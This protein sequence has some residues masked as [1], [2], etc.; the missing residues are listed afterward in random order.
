MRLEKRDMVVES[1]ILRRF[2]HASV[3]FRRL[4]EEMCTF[5]H[6]IEVSSQKTKVTIWADST[7]RESALSFFLLKLLADSNIYFTYCCR[8][9]DVELAY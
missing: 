3:P 9:T 7:I 8:I 4:S 5:V 2:I 1:M 6:V